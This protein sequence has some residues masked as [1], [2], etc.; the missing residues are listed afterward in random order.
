MRLLVLFLAATTALATQL[1]R[2]EK[3]QPELIQTV[4]VNGHEAIWAVGPYPVH[5]KNQ[6]L[7]IRRMV[8]GHVLIWTEGGFTYRLETDL[9]LE[10]ALKIAESLR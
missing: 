6:G 10:E 9:P 4:Q 3:I 2:F 1:P 8:N 7:D 5:L